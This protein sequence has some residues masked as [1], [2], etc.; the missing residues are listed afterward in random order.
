MWFTTRGGT[1]RRKITYFARQVAGFD[2][3]SGSLREAVSASGFDAGLI[4]HSK[5]V[6][7]KVGSDR[8]FWV[9]S[10]L[11]SP[12]FPLFAFALLNTEGMGIVFTIME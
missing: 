3:C 6:T 12:L 11:L 5:R 2:G 7:T 4:M 10:M 9:G 8:D 1:A